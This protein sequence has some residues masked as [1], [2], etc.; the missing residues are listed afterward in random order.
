MAAN[1]KVQ[2][3]SMDEILAS[4]RRIMADDE[5]PAAA[6]RPLDRAPAAF[7]PEP[8][9][10]SEPLSRA[11][12]PRG[13]VSRAESP[14]AQ[15]PAPRRPAPAAMPGPDARAAFLHEAPYAPR[16]AATRAAPPPEPRPPRAEFTFPG[17][18]PVRR[19]RPEPE[20]FD[21]PPPVIDRDRVQRELLAA[22]N[23]QSDAAPAPPVADARPSRADLEERPRLQPRTEHAR[24]EH[25]RTEHARLEPAPR[26]EAPRTEP[27][28]GASSPAQGPGRRDL[29][30]PGVDAA[31]AAAFHSLGNVVLPQKERTVE[32]LVKEILRPMLKDWLDQNLPAIVDGLV[33]AEI[34]RVSRQPR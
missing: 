26:V 1:P 17:D 12:G 15:E 16:P 3:P 22:L 6:R 19:S 25:A 4:I 23:R 29:L 5:Q 18:A 34:E 30:S 27:P 10:R 32:D 11:E 28:R 7:R 2:E 21:P 33:R 20:A 13:E 31:V 24:T 14:R 9:S 8:V